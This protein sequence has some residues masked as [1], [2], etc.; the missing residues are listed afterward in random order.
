M[1]SKSKYKK[2]F[3]I[4]A[5]QTS[6][7]ATVLGGFR[8]KKQLLDLYDGRSLLKKRSGQVF[9]N[10]DNENQ[11]HIKSESEE[12][13]FSETERD[14]G[15]GDEN[16][17][18]TSENEGIDQT[19]KGKEHSQ[20]NNKKSQNKAPI[21]WFYDDNDLPNSLTAELLHYQKHF[22]EFDQKEESGLATTAKYLLNRRKKEKKVKDVGRDRR[23]SKN[24]VLRFEVHEKLMNFLAPVKR[25]E[26]E[27]ERVRMVL[28]G[29]KERESDRRKERD[30][31]KEAEEPEEPEDVQLV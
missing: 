19:P 31:G 29:E 24:R 9:E 5:L 11:D 22:S 16:E 17:K 1:T 2:N 26:V 21:Q 15:F 7:F 27:G 3:R 10:S 18:M 28:F 20:E 25:E 23:A 8:R 4:K 14:L 12:Q 13:D 30:A 6:P